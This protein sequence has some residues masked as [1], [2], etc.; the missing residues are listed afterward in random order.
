MRVSRQA[1]Y[2]IR[3]VMD[4]SVNEEARIREIAARQ[5]LSPAH[6]GRISQ[7]L[8]KAG[9]LTT[10]RG[11]LGHISLSCNPEDIS[12][13]EVVEA[14]DGPLQ[15]DR[16]LLAP[17]KCGREHVCPV[18]KIGQEILLHSMARLGSTT[19]GDLKSSPV[20]ESAVG[21]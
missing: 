20:L 17:G 18:Y 9:V 1:D 19:F 7:V 12:L 8:A 10:K 5:G 21:K 6:V 11:R 15:L 2:A 13:L 4:L 14:V 3:V 16:C